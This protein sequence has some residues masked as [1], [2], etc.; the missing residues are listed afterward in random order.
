MPNQLKVC[1]C[2]DCRTYVPIHPNNIEAQKDE[3][4]FKTIHVKHRTGILPI[5]ELIPQNEYDKPYKCVSTKARENALDSL[6][7]TFSD[8]L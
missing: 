6:T 1:A 2:F 4:W 8:K 7:K 3:L 5:S